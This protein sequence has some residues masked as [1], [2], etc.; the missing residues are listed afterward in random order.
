MTL[1]AAYSSTRP[2]E[3]TFPAKVSTEP[4]FFYGK[5]THAMHEE[6]AA[7]TAAGPVEIVSNVKLAVPV[8]VHAGDAIEVRGE[9][10]HDR[11]RAP[12][13]HWTHRDPAGAHPDGFIQFRGRVYA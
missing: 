2:A 6:F 11:G 5:R 10:V 12:I 1:T 4:H 3:V 7:A 13:V 8:P 9:M